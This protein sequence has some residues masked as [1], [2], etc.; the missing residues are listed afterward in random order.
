MGAP[1]N[2]AVLRSTSPGSAANFSVT[3]SANVDFVNIDGS[4]AI[5]P[6]DVSIARDHLMGRTIPGD[7]TLCN[8]VGFFDPLEGGADC[9]VVEDV[10]VLDRLAASFNVTAENACKP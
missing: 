6:V 8:V 10:F 1:G 4:F 3:G 5:D 2:L 7:I 9:T